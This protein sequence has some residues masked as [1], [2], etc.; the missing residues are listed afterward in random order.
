[1]TMRKALSLARVNGVAIFQAVEQGHG[2]RDNDAHVCYHPEQ[3]S[4]VQKWFDESFLEGI[5]L[6]KD[7]VIETSIRKQSEDQKKY[8]QCVKQQMKKLV[9]E[10]RAIIE[11]IQIQCAPV[12]CA[13]IVRGKDVQVDPCDNI[14]NEELSTES[15]EE[16]SSANSDKT[17][18]EEN[19]STS[20]S[21]IGSVWSKVSVIKKINKISDELQKERVERERER[22]EMQIEREENRKFMESMRNLQE[23]I[24]NVNDDDTD[25]EISIKVRAIARKVK[26]KDRKVTA[27][28]ACNSNFMSNNTA[29]AS[30][31]TRKQ[32]LENELKQLNKTGLQ[33]P[34][35]VTKCDSSKKTAHSEITERR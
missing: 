1:M 24:L 5:A 30:Q 14:R 32:E 4:L 13:E 27:S 23:L 12:T 19:N 16:A 6:S 3:R 18:Q 10:K 29:S 15:G 35:N 28:T 34:P 21:K 26:K 22:K 33:S 9:T 11:N 7:R 31:T 17:E 2:A 20:S 25:E 8:S